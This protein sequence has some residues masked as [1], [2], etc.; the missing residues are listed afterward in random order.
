MHPLL[1][2]LRLKE[3]GLQSEVMLQRGVR[4][5]TQ[6]QVRKLQ[7]EIAELSES[8]QDPKALKDK[9][10]AEAVGIAGTCDLPCGSC[11]V[12][13]G[14]ACSPLYCYNSWDVC[15]S[16]YLACKQLANWQEAR[17]VP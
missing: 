17:N 3:T 14:H 4:A 5:D 8:I 12:L 11:A 15:I 7:C 10:R 9:V 2:K 13:Y 16:A 1:Q 6:T